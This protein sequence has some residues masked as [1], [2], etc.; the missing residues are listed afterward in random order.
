ML[1]SEGIA[2]LLQTRFKLDQSVLSGGGET[3]L[4][5]AFSLKMS[6]VSSGQV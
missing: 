5:I 6:E 4:S 2:E 1:C 3:T